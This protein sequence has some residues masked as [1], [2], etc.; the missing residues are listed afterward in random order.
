MRYSYNY[1][2]IE[3]LFIIDVV[4]VFAYLYSGYS[5][6][7]YFIFKSICR[8]LK[9]LCLFVFFAGKNNYSSAF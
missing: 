1:F 4:Y 5:H 9:K 7:L 8:A 2:L 3:S 6:T